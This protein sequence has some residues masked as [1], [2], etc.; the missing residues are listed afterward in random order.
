MNKTYDAEV[1][2]LLLPKSAAAAENASQIIKNAREIPRSLSFY[3][4][5]IANYPD[6]TDRS[7]GMSGEKRLAFWNSKI[8]LSQIRASGVVKIDSFDPVQ[9][10]AELISVK[11]ANDLSVVLGKYYNAETDLAVRFIDGPIVY[12]VS[13]ADL[14]QLIFFSALVGILFGIIFYFLVKLISREKAPAENLNKFAF[15]K[16][17]TPYSPETIEEIPE[18]VYS[19]DKKAEAPANL[20]TAE[21]ISEETPK[22]FP[23]ESEKSGTARE[24]TP[25]E[26]RE[27]LNKLLRGDA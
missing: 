21:E 17:K 16:E 20:P 22:Y 5:L 2:I 27:R 15:G 11:V 13:G 10:Q 4:R 6:I 9:S 25:D 26:V 18:E 12:Q 19:F 1:R 14:T 23:L 8:K 24:A 3:D 7:A